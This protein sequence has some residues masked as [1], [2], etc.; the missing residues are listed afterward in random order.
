MAYLCASWIEQS[1][2]CPC[3][4]IS[5]ASLAR[6][7]FEDLDWGE[8]RAKQLFAAEVL[9]LETASNDEEVLRVVSDVLSRC[10]EMRLL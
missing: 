7:V 4:Q 5:M 10:P 3:A 6:G 2:V 8:L 1:S 9:R